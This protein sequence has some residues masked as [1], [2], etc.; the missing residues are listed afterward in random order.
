MLSMA[1]IV[2]EVWLAVL[3]VGGRPDDCLCLFFG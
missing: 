2:E 3:L 1:A